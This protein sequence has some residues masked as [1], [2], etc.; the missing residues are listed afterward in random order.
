MWRRLFNLLVI[1]SLVLCVATV[2]LWT[3]TRM[4]HRPVPFAIGY[5]GWTFLAQ[6]CASD[7]GVHFY[8]ER[9]PFSQDGFS[10]DKLSLERADYVLDVDQYGKYGF[11]WSKLGIVVAHLGKLTRIAFDFEV[12]A[13]TAVVIPYWCVLAPALVPPVLRLRA[14]LRQQRHRRQ[15]LCPACGYDLRATPD[16]CPECGA[17]A[18]ETA[19]ASNRPRPHAM[20]GM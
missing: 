19:G 7:S 13:F 14:I 15:G 11:R 6:V 20:R 2:V 9:R 3:W 18:G 10:Q 16:R 5:D 4:L 1:V 12:F 17:V 8:V